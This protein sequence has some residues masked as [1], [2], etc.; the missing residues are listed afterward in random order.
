MAYDI[1]IS[2]R[3]KGAGAGV[4]GELQAKLESR[5]YKVFL[6]VDNIASGDFPEQ[7]EEAIKSC[8]DFLLILSPGMLDRCV[9]EEDWVRHEIVLAEQYG[10]NIIGVSLPGFVMPEPEALP[11]PLRKVPEKQVFIWSHEY[12]NASLVKIEENMVSF[13]RKKKRQHRNFIWLS[14]A[15]V[16]M[17]AFVVVWRLHQPKIVPQ[18]VVEEDPALAMAKEVSERFSAYMDNGDS[19]LGVY[20]NPATTAQFSTFMEGVTSYNSALALSRQHPE[21]SLNTKGLSRKVDSL[22]Y[23]RKQRLTVELKAVPVFLDVNDEA[24]ARERYENA[25]TLALTDAEKDEVMTLGKKFK[26]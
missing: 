17:A 25:R 24:T 2:Y 5:G 10:K 11:E 18:E 20:P 4:A 9:D 3:R 26:N 8:H 6:D 14:L 15:A 13:R 16:L 23:L 7:I 21:V 19:L 1:F 12:R 22:D